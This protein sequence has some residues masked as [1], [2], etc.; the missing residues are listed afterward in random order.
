MSG[1]RP[2]D[3]DRVLL[4]RDE[5]PRQ[6]LGQDV[7]ILLQ[8][9]DV[10]LAGLLGEPAPQ[11]LQRPDVADAGLLLD[12]RVHVGDGRQRLR[13]I[14]RR[15]LGEFDQHVDRDWRR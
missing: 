8:R 6:M 4:G 7:D 5:A 10:G 12:R 11:G 13:R 14:E 1:M 15:A 2:D 9:R 3:H